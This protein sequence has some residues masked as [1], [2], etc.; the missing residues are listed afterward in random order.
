MVY[1]V[2][3]AWCG[4]SMGIKECESNMV[5]LELESLGLP[6]ISHGICPICKTAVEEKY[7]LGKKGGKQNVR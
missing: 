7:G 5:A 2:K 6:I 1:Q 3:C 4:K